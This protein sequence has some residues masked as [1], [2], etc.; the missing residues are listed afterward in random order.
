MRYIIFLL[1]LNTPLWAGQ[2]AGRIVD[3]NTRVQV[4][5]EEYLEET[6]GPV[7]IE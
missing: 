2:I 3:A 7:N 4:E 5:I 1:C 6:G